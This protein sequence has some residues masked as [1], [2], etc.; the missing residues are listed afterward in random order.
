MSISSV[1]NSQSLGTEHQKNLYQASYHKLDRE[2]TS[3][4]KTITDLTSDAM[5]GAIEKVNDINI[6]TT[7]TETEE[8]QFKVKV[9]DDTGNTDTSDFEYFLNH[10]KGLSKEQTT[11]LKSAIN[12]ATDTLS[13]TQCQSD[14]Y[15]LRIAQTNLEFKYISERLVPEE[16]RDKFN[17]YVDDM[18]NQL[19]NHFVNFEKIFAEQM[20]GTNDSNLV[21]LGWKQKGKDMLDT[22]NGGMDDFQSSMRQFTQ[23]YNG[24]DVQDSSKVKSQIDNIYKTI[25]TNGGSRSKDLATEIKNL[26]EKWNG[27]M[28]ALGEKN[29][30]FTTSINRVV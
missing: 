21:N 16:Y 6:L 22:V 26:S 20:I 15:G 24:V 1:S 2:K 28:D 25:I 4:A 11:T 12:A 3:Y 29:N 9:N 10:M 13:N 8:E 5:K 7:S 27:V 18:T 14:T 30:K 17:S 23:L 19:S